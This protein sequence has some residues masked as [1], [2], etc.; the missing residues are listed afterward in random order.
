MNRS[1]PMVRPPSPSTSTPPTASKSPRHRTA[2]STSPMASSASPARVTA[3]NL[4]L[5]YQ[6]QAERLYRRAV[7]EFER[8]KKLR[9]ELSDEPVSE[10]DELTEPQENTTDPSPQEPSPNEPISSPPLRPSGA[11]GLAAC[12]SLPAGSAG[13]LVA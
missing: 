10:D 5:R 11:G 12:Q 1:A 3:F 9:A 13:D 8:V 2:I 7:E 6:A 4:F